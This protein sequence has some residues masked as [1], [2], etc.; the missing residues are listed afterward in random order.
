[1]VEGYCVKCRKKVEIQD[2][3]PKVYMV[4]GNKKYAVQG[5]CPYCHTKVT[6]FL[7]EPYG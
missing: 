2:P 3:K 1:M 4:R 5:R 6:R 7:S